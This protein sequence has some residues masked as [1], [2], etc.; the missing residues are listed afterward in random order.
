MKHLASRS[1]LEQDLASVMQIEVSAYPQPW[2]EGIFRDCFKAD[3]QCTLYELEGELIGY[4]VMSMA[5][6]EAHV[7]N[8]CIHPEYQG[9]GLGR[10]VLEQVLMVAGGGHTGTVFLEVR[11]SN[12][13]ARRLYESAGFNEI[14]QR[15][16][17]Y[18]AARGRE[19]ALV[20]AKV[21]V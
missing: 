5:A 2:T 4:S 14:G 6:G 9:K 11:I 3:C 12:A 15:F 16:N 1:M 17:Y 19:D 8:L 7:L 13:A 18:P 20:F 10:A 21:L